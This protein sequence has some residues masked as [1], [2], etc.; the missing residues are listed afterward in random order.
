MTGLYYITSV[1]LLA[2]KRTL[3][4]WDILTVKGDFPL[5][6]HSEILDLLCTRHEVSS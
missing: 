2:T 1:Q 4:K 3:L 5:L 6:R